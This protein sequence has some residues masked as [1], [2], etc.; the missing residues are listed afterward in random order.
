MPRYILQS[1]MIVPNTVPL[2]LFGK[3][4]WIHSRTFWS[5]RAACGPLPKIKFSRKE[6]HSREILTIHAW[7]SGVRPT[8]PPAIYGKTCI[9]HYYIYAVSFV[10][11]ISHIGGQ[12]EMTTVLVV[13]SP[14]IKYIPSR[15]HW[16]NG[17]AIA[18]TTTTTLTMAISIFV[19]HA[20]FTIVMLSRE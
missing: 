16:T 4:F 6:K 18:A 8:R 12:L 14:R 20:L 13:G 2:V 11:R 10:S 17:I 5:V 15:R 3:C 7:V 9:T 19:F 1:E